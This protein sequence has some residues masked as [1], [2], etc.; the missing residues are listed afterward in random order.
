MPEIQ[1]RIMSGQVTRYIQVTQ[2]QK[3]M[4]LTKVQVIFVTFH[5][6]SQWDRLLI[7]RILLFIPNFGES[8]H[9]KDLTIPQVHFLPPELIQGR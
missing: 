9:S 1:G 7:G 8:L 6:I 2:P 3:S 4:S 5:V